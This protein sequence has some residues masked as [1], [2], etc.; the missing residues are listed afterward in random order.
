MSENVGRMAISRPLVIAAALLA[1]GWRAQ[2]PTVTPTAGMVID[3][4]VRLRPGTYRLPAP[5]TAAAITIRGT[6]ITVDFTGVTIE[7]GDPHADPDGYTGTGIAVDASA[8]VTI[9]GGAVRGYKVALLA[10]QSPHLHVTGADYSYNWKPR[11][12]SGIERES[13]LDWLTYHHNEQDEWL[14]YGAALY[15]AECDDAEIDHV[16]AVQNQNGLLATRSARLTIWNNTFSWNSGLGIGFYR[17][18]D[19]TVAGNGIDWD[20]RG[21]S[22]GFYNRGQDSAAFLLFEQ[23]SRNRVARNSMT[24]GGDGVFLWAGQSTMDTGQGGANDNVF[25]DNDVSHTVTNG[26]EAT[27]S[28]NQFIRNRI[29]DCWH[30]IWGGYSYDS[31]IQSN[32]FGHN[33]DGIAIEH[34]QHN[35]IEDNRFDGDDT[36]IRIWANASQDPSFAYAKARDT[37]SHDY[38]IERNTFVN[39]KVALNLLRTSDVRTSGN[40]YTNVAKPVQDGADVQGLSFERRDDTVPHRDAESVPRVPG[41]TAAPTIGARPGRDAIIVDEWGPYDFRSPKLWPEGAPGTRPLK[42]RVLGPSGR[43]KLRSIRGAS[44]TAR[45]GRVPGTVVVTPVGRGADW[46]I[47]LDYVG[48]EVVTPRG[49][50]FAAGATVPFSYGQ[51]DPA[52]DW[53]V[54]YWSFDGATDPVTSPDAFDAH[55]RETPLETTTASH[56]DLLTSGPI[57]KDLP[58]ERVALVADGVVD[59]PRGAFTLTTISD[60]GLRVWVDGALV[61]DRWSVHESALDHISLTGGKHRLR[62][63]YFQATGWAE[64]A[65]RFARVVA[66]RP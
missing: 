13:L 41:E 14:R 32:T 28:R 52:I 38:A 29:E 17:T 33:T 43:W 53:A 9:R 42:L 27:F 44:V 63:Q 47:D 40:T 35:T 54:K 20:V 2:A 34:G 46:K 65:L 62:V 5:G 18:T 19:S 37:A 1:A 23:S 58:R 6:G 12:W 49:D 26:I 39:E 57:A 3:H 10:R 11:L 48:A 55:L 51:F 59:L 24:H 21:Y 64:L 50:H 16:R 45:E 25:V 15:L 30:G 60:D 7:G 61:I 8:G 56:L 22:H 66:A 36:A 4:S 31:V